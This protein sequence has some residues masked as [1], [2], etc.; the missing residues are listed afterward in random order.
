MI[1]SLSKRIAEVICDRN[2]QIDTNLALMSILEELSAWS[3]YLIETH[4]L[5][6]TLEL[7]AIEMKVGKIPNYLDVSHHYYMLNCVSLLTII[8]HCIIEFVIAN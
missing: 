4:V 5:K 1:V 6:G 7:R 2:L 3:V 8:Y